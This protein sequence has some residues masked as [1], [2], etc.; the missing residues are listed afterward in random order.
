MKTN[1]KRSLTRMNRFV[2]NI[3]KRIKRT[4]SSCFK[5]IKLKRLNTSKFKKKRKRCLRKELKRNLLFEK[6][7]DNKENLRLSENKNF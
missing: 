1:E 3:F 7:Q 2:L 6:E 4:L 5:S